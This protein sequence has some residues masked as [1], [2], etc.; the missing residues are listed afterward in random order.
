[1]D[2]FH[3]PKTDFMNFPRLTYSFHYKK[4][5]P[6]PFKCKVFINFIHIN[7]FPIGWTSLC[8]IYT[9]KNF[10]SPVTSSE[11]LKVKEKNDLKIMWDNNN[12][13]KCFFIFLVEGSFMIWGKKS[14]DPASH[15]S[16][17]VGKEGSCFTAY[18]LS[19]Y[20]YNYKGILEILLI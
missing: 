4:F 12:A 11:N 6:S 10:R 17:P 9:K 20:C 18:K 16:L 8:I 15:Y 7:L 2:C 19:F 5:L 13:N 3:F 1:M 14:P